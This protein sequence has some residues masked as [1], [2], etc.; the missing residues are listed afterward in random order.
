MG[1]STDISWADAVP[2]TTNA[3][4]HYLAGA[5]DA[6][7]HISIIKSIRSKGKKYA[8]CPVYYQP[9]M[10]F[11]S[12]NPKV[13]ELFKTAFRAGFVQIYDPRR[14]NHR[15]VY[16]WK[17]DTA[18]TTGRICRLLA[19]MLILKRAQARLVADY[20]DA[21]KAQRRE[22]LTSAPPPYRLSAESLALRAVY[23]EAVGELNEPRNRR[24]NRHPLI[25]SDAAR[26]LLAQV[27]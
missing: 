1:I 26:Q 17:S 8:H 14:A 24:L 22:Q 12:T 6:D 19:P 5:L 18:E 10:G 25:V 23:W 27:S 9:V 13:P 20:C 11:T 3:T 7:G 21:V 16:I 15:I 2:A 4:L